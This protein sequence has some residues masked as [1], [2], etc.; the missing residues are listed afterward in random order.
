LKTEGN[1]ARKD[2]IIQIG[3]VRLEKAKFLR[4]G[5]FELF[6]C[7][8][9]TNVSELVGICNFE[10]DNSK[11]F[12]NTEEGLLTNF[13]EFAFGSYIFTYDMTKNI[14]FLESTAKRINYPIEDECLDLVE[15]IHKLAKKYLVSEAIKDKSIESIARILGVKNSFSQ[16]ALDSSIV[17]FHSYV[18]LK[19]MEFEELNSN[20]IKLSIVMHGNDEVKKKEMLDGIFAG[21]YKNQNE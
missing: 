20:L 13:F 12:V 15:S 2:K 16:S 21:M 18:L 11:I 19:Q 17:A 3:A 9:K 14:K 10:K 7:N 8:L 6:D 5:D 4:D 1:V